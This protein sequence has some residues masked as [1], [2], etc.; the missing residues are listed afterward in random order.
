MNK[1]ETPILQEICLDIKEIKNNHLPHIYQRLDW[2]CKK[3]T[4]ILGAIGLLGVIIAVVG[5][6]LAL[7][8][9]L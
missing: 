5:I 2:L 1:Q 9:F 4:F 3:D 6:L 7:K 8:T